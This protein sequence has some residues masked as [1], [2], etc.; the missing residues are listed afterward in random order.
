MRN[1]KLFVGIITVFFLLTF[2][3]SASAYTLNNVPDYEWH[4]GCS[5][6]AAGMMMA[7]YD[8]NGYAGLRYDDLIQGGV[9]ELSNYA[10]PGL[11]DSVIASQGHVDDFWT[12]YLNSGDDPNP[13]TTRQFDSLADFMGTSQDS[14]G[15]FDGGTTF[16]NFTDGSR[17]Y[18]ID[19][20]GYGASYYDSSGM[21]GMWEYF[22]YAGYDISKANF[23]NQY[24]IEQGLTYGFEW[25]DYVE[26]ID[27]G[28][29]VMIHVTGHSVL[30]YGYDNSTGEI[31]LH[32]TWSEG[33]HRMVW[34]EDYFGRDHFAVTCF[35]PEGG[36]PVPEPATIFLV[37]AGLLGLVRFRK[38]FR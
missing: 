9:A 38:K 6:T 11:A 37:G 22:T 13:G 33:E 15:N 16:W 5:P 3:R 1:R 31:I 23:Y 21:Y 24:I 26:E 14:Q 20:F 25:A 28:R 29:P 35:T 10:G 8:I 27:A 7:Y 17:L 32:D 30:G 18:A 36:S 34:G 2:L 19:I 12:G 4:Y